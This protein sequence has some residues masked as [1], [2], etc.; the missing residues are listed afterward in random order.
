MGSIRAWMRISVCLILFFGLFPG[1][2]FLWAGGPLEDIRSTTERILEILSDPGLEGSEHRAER[3]KKVREV[4]DERFDW[5]AISRSSL[6]TQWRNL[7]AAEKDEF[8][9]VFSSLV[10]R[11]YMDRLENYSGE[12][13]IYLGEES[14]GGRAR[15]RVKIVTR[16]NQEIPVEYRLRSGNGEWLVYD[17]LIEGVSLVKNYRV[18]FNDFLTKSSYAELMER[19]KAKV[20]QQS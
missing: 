1:A 14:D 7:S 6:S 3:R 11:T 18:Q 16:K 20:E 4:V 2:Q 8:T 10:E 13:V 5:E 9:R 17:I 15:V 12:E 19:L